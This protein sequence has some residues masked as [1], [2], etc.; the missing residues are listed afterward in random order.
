MYLLISRAYKN[1][2]TDWTDLKLHMVAYALI[3]RN[4]CA[5]KNIPAANKFV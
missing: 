1:I 2:Y 5:S 3:I 4:Y